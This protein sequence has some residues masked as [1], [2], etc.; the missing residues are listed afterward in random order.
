TLQRSLLHLVVGQFRNIGRRG[1][2][3]S[4]Q[5]VLQHPL[6]ALHRR[7]PRRIRRQRQHRRLR[8]NPAPL[9]PLEGN[10]PELVPPIIGGRGAGR[11]S[12][13]LRQR[14]VHEGVLAIQE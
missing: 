11:Q 10:L 13:E 7:G 9:R 3:G 8:Q 5:D 1:G 4:A 6:A 2:K 12:I 14:L